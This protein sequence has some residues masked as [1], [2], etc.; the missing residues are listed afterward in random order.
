[1]EKIKKAKI[2]DSEDQKNKSGSGRR[3]KKNNKKLNSSGFVDCVDF[4]KMMNNM[5]DTIQ[6]NLN[7][8]MRHFFFRCEMYDFVLVKNS[9]NPDALRLIE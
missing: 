1:M 5:V 4:F 2:Q 9:T 7:D 6:R 8:N 3:N